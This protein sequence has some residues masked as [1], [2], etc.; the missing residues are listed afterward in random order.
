MSL[1]QLYLLRSCDACL[2]IDSHFIFDGEGD[3]TIRVTLSYGLAKVRSRSGTQEGR[4]N[5]KIK[6]LAPKGYLFGAARHEDCNGG[7]C[8]TVRCNIIA[9][10]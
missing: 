9:D 8:F 6:I 5:L 4:S 10:T 1:Y 2:T 7:L 3:V